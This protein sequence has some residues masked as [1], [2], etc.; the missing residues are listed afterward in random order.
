MHVLFNVN[1]KFNY[2]SA[3]ND[4]NHPPIIS[5]TINLNKACPCGGT[6]CGWTDF[7]PPYHYYHM[8]Y[9]DYF[10]KQTCKYFIFSC[11]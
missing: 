1:I 3:K 2:P 6:E 8:L 4:Q 5:K 10:S 7:C 9:T 11:F